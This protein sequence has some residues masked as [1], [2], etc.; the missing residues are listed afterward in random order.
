MKERLKTIRKKLGL[1]Q[2]E[3]ANKL[4]MSQQAYS[5]LENGINPITERHIKPICSIFGINE[6]WLLTG[7]GEPFVS[8]PNKERLEYILCKLNA[9]N[10]EYLLSI[11][12]AMLDKQNED[13]PS[14]PSGF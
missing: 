7:N 4:G 5:A 10:Q 8:R 6:N 12:K 2:T 3:F 11:A 9:T 14:D 13:D 1:N